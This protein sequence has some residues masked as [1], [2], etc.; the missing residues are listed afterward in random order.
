MM[1]NLVKAH[2]LSLLRFCFVMQMDGCG[3][4]NK[5]EAEGPIPLL[6]V[7]FRSEKSL[8]TSGLFQWACGYISDVLSYVTYNVYR[9]D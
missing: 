1:K 3:W 2:T 6:L 8:L 4:R 9:Q 7:F 5:G